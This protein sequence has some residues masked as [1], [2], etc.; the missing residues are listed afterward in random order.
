[1][2]L[3][4]SPHEVMSGKNTTRKER[5]DSKTFPKGSYRR[6]NPGGGWNQPK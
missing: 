5:V 3:G 4:W 6:I 1:M 2:Q